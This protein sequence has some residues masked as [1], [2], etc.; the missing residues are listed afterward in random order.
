MEKN[1][2]KDLNDVVGTV[3]MIIIWTIFFALLIGSAI[4]WVHTGSPFY[5]ISG[6]IGAAGVLTQLFIG[7][8]ERTRKQ[9]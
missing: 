5:M 4:L 2:K 8:R 1:Q 9:D 3:I 6:M 7:Y